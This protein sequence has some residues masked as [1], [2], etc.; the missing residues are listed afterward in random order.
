MFSLIEIHKD[1]ILRYTQHIKYPPIKSTVRRIKNLNTGSISEVFSLLSREV[2]A[3]EVETL[4]AGFSVG[5]GVGVGAEVGAE[6]GVGAGVST[7]GKVEA[8]LEEVLPLLEPALG[9][10]W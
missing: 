1:L 10:P 9:A 5:V 6:V 8:G 4:G 2:F 7:G 3:F